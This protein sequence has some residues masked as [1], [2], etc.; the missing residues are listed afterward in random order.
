MLAAA[1]RHFTLVAAFEPY[2]DSPMKSARKLNSGVRIDDYSRFGVRGIQ[3]I[4]RCVGCNSL[5]LFHRAGDSLPSRNIHRN[6]VERQLIFTA[7]VHV[8][9]RAVGSVIWHNMVFKSQA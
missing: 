9:R 6:F 8:F 3:L 7:G 4:S 5:Q 2:T 1:E